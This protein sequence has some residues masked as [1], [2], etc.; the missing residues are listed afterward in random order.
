M[1]LDTQGREWN[2]ERR[3]VKA[4][5]VA[6]ARRLYATGL[7][8]IREIAWMMGLSERSVSTYTRELRRGS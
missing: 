8:K 3:L 1:R 5:R 4:E 2:W 7:Y 6:K